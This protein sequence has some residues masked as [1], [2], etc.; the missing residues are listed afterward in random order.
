MWAACRCL[1]LAVSSGQMPLDSKRI[2]L[3]ST[4]ENT[5]GSRTGKPRYRPEPVL[6]G[7]DG[8]GEVHSQNGLGILALHPR[9]T[10][11]RGS[12]PVTIS[13]GGR[14]PLRTTNHL[15]C[16]STNAA[17]SPTRRKLRI[18]G[19]HAAPAR[20][21]RELKRRVGCGS[22]SLAGWSSLQERFACFE[23]SGMSAA[24]VISR[25]MVGHPFWPAVAI[26]MVSRQRNMPIFSFFT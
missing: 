9:L 18:R 22:T 3:F 26:T 20:H 16:P 19:W 10:D 6:R 14:W 24:I 7:H 25:R 2:M 5:T 13:R 4:R 23:Q 21:L 1:F 11:F 8:L 15:R 12:A 17:F